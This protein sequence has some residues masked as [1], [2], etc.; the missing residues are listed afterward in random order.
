MKSL[1]N[2]WKTDYEE[3][4]RQKRRSSRPGK[5]MEGEGKMNQLYY[6][7]RK[8]KGRRNAIDRGGEKEDFSSGIW[9]K[10][11]ANN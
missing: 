5:E 7:G 4:K 1:L 11:Y 8:R 10:C 3:S 6:W 9:D 2:H